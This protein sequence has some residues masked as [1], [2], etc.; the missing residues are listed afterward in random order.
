MIKIILAFFNAVRGKRTFE[1]LGA[2]QEEQECPYKVEP[3]EADAV[4]GRSIAASP[5]VIEAQTEPRNALMHQM[6]MDYEVTQNG[7]DFVSEECPLRADSLCTAG[8]VPQFADCP[9]DYKNCPDFCDAYLKEHGSKYEP[10]DEVVD[11]VEEEVD[12]QE[13]ADSMSAITPHMMGVSPEKNKTH[14]AWQHPMTATEAI[15]LA[16]NGIDP[17]TGKIDALAKEECKPSYQAPDMLDHPEH[18][19]TGNMS[20]IECWDHYELAM[21]EAEFRGAMKANLYK[22]IFR[23]RKKGDQEK[24]IE[25]LGKCIRYLNRWIEFEKGV[26]VRWTKS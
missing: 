17:L 14:K 20:G 6:D 16:E 3:I 21:E 1:D 8:T 5:E 15:T 24:F 25:D 26:R 19:T 12:V 7:K 10:T 13:L 4:Y 2:D 22:Y 9:L 18:Y 23:G 11:Q